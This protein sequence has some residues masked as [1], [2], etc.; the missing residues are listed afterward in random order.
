M[1]EAEV[2]PPVARVGPTRRGPSFRILEQAPVVSCW[3]PK[4]VTTDRPM[5]VS[6]D[7]RQGEGDSARL[8]TCRLPSTAP[9]GS[10][11][12][13]GGSHK[14]LDISGKGRSK[15]PH[16][17]LP[18]S[19]GLGL[20]PVQQAA[21]TEKVSSLKFQSSRSLMA[22]SCKPAAAWTITQSCARR[23]ALS[24]PDGRPPNFKAPSISNESTIQ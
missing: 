9:L 24:A 19:H 5:A 13:A 16:P 4:Q 11:E 6:S 12:L 7:Q 10:V 21:P 17:I 20:R 2:A 3:S 1:T 14:F 23:P 18:Y 22:A 8:R 15:Q